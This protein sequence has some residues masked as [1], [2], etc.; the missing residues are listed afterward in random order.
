MRARFPAL[1]PTVAKATQAQLNILAQR[2]GRVSR[3]SG[4]IDSSNVLASKRNTRGPTSSRDH[5]HNTADPQPRPRRSLLHNMARDR[6]KVRS[7]GMRCNSLHS[8]LPRTRPK[9]KQSTES[10]VSIGLL[11]HSQSPF[12]DKQCSS[13]YNHIRFRQN[14]T[15]LRLGAAQLKGRF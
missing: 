10:I 13:S 14:F 3:L 9:A 5:E 4:R 7:P 1:R 8:P 6:R 2:N 12:R 15:R 11:F